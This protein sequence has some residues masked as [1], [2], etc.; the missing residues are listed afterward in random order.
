MRP[1]A[2]IACF[3]MI[4]SCYAYKISSMEE[5]YQVDRNRITG[6]TTHPLPTSRGLSAGSMILARSLDPAVK[7]RDV[8]FAVEPEQL[9]TE[10]S[11]KLQE[12]LDA[13]L[14]VKSKTTVG[15]VSRHKVTFSGFSS[16]IFIIGDDPVSRQWLNDHAKQLR[17]LHALGF[18]TNIE[19]PEALQE[20][21][22]VHDLPLL[23]A[24]VDDLMI[25]LDARHYPLMMNEGDV[26]Q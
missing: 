7:P 23:P 1:F 21:Q 3:L 8:G 15:I 14:P 12:S 26:W 20:I 16:P 13:R 25:L 2:M 6:I 22:T 4:A 10:E 19:S 5:F 18:I 24:N 11:L 9:F 17:E